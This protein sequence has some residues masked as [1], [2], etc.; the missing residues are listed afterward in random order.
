ME[1]NKVEQA[2]A[3]L[4]WPKE[5]IQVSGF[6]HEIMNYRYHWHP[7]Q[8]ELNILL[9]GSQE[10]CRG[11]ETRLL[12]EDDVILVAPG[13]GHASY[14]QQANTRALV[15]H[16]STAA[17]KA[18]TKKGYTYAFPC[19][20]SSARTR[21]TPSYNQIRF[22]AAQ[23]YQA[24]SENGPYASLIARASLDLL[25]AVL[26]TQFEPSPM[27]NPDEED[28]RHRQTIQSLIGY[29][30][31]HY[32]EKITLEDLAA[33][34]DYNRT[35]ISTLFKQTVGVNFYEYLMRVRFQKA[36]LDLSMTGK[37]LTAVALDN[38]F[39][40]LKSFNARFREILHRS[41]AEYRAQL[42]P[43]RVMEAETRSLISARD[44]ILTKKLEEYAGK[45]FE[46]PGNRG[47]NQ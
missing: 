11:T 41:P 39:S 43:D 29:I 15:L 37:N 32:R 6:A 45:P 24:A 46:A 19:C 3:E 12:K 2:Y 10:F 18:F 22:Y 38:G 44:P 26:C 31:T 9:H 5:R 14:A 33:Y 30:E 16:F 27:K 17:F 35:Y 4:Q 13:T 20:G 47:I 23:I 28:D 34:S 25:L 1:E 40:D 42:S 21:Q 36:L 8:Y 7:S